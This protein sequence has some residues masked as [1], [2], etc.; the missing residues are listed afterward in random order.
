MISINREQVV[1]PQGNEGKSQT[2]AFVFVGLEVGG[3]EGRDVVHVT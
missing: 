2:L 3:R 1:H